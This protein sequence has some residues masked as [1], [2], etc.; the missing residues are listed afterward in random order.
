A[1]VFEHG[2][3]LWLAVFQNGEVFFL[4][5]GHLVAGVVSHEYV[6]HHQ[7]TGRAKGDVVLG[8]YGNQGRDEGDN[9]PARHL[10]NGTSRWLLPCAWRRRWLA[11]RSS[12]RLPP[13]RFPCN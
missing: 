3:F 2:H 6:D 5:P 4:Q 8:S 10:R 12:S 13:F 1:L 11:G 7:V 9:E